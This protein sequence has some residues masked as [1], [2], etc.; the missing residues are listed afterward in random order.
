MSTGTPS[1]KQHT[2]TRTHTAI[3][4]TPEETRTDSSRTFWHLRP[5]RAKSE[6]LV[7][8]C[9]GPMSLEFVHL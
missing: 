1:S 9:L 5:F 2:H 4:L 8:C 3:V 7:S 6:P